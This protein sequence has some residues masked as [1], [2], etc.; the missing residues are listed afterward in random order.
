MATK[1]PAEQ[2]PFKT[3]IF[4]MQ[5][6]GTTGRATVPVWADDEGTAMQAAVAAYGADFAIFNQPMIVETRF[7][8]GISCD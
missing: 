7:A 6:R 1:K 8:S 2:K 5:R 3:F 4:Q